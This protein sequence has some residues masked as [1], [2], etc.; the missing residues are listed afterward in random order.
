MRSPH[1]LLA[2][3][4]LLL[5]A[6]AGC[7]STPFPTPTPTSQPTASDLASCLEGTWALDVDDLETQL[8]DSVDVPGVPVAEFSVDGDGTI[9][10]VADGDVSGTL[11]V[12]AT[13]TLDDG[14]PFD[15]PLDADFA[16][17]WAVGDLPDT[18]TIEDWSY[19]AETTGA[20][21]AEL[22]RP[23]DFSDLPEIEAD[24]SGDALVLSAGTVPLEVRWTRADG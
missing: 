22:P 11:Q 3:G 5:L 14:T 20:G 6:L 15:V 24:C 21:G 18:I 10:F 12:R 2:G 23:M 19:D 13:G 17:R 16:G 4:G 7:T 1:T 9:G 8:A